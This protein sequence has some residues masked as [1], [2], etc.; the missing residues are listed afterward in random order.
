MKKTTILAAAALA[1]MSAALVAPSAVADPRVSVPFV[2]VTAGDDGMDV[3][4][5]P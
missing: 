1:G 2:P 4:S 3:P 5:A